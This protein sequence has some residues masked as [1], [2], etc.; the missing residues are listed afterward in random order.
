MNCENTQIYSRKK[1]EELYSQIDESQSSEKVIQDLKS[2]VE[3][4]L[5]TIESCQATIILSGS[6][7][8][9][10]EFHKAL[11]Q[12]SFTEATDTFWTYP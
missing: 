8:I 2:L 4:M 1:F 12:S 3:S 7:K 11:E 10:E 9:E 6:P 5:C